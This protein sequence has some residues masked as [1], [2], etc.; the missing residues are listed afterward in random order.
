V[1]GTSVGGWA[2]ILRRHAAA[3]IEAG[4]CKTGADPPRAA[5]R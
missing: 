2:L 5:S 1:D 3:A 4:L